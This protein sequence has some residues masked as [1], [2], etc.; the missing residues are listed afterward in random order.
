MHWTNFLEE[1][2]TIYSH[3]GYCQEMAK[4]KIFHLEEELRILKEKYDADEIK[5]YEKAL[6]NWTKEEIEV[7][8]AKTCFYNFSEEEMRNVSE[9]TKQELRNSNRSFTK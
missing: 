9:E 6:V 1:A 5:L 7:A 2:G 4:I 8:K 3:D